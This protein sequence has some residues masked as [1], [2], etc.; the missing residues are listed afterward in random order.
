MEALTSALV[1]ACLADHLAGRVPEPG[2]AER[3]VT[4]V[5]GPEGRTAGDPVDS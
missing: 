4:A 3:V 1:G 2:W 5:L